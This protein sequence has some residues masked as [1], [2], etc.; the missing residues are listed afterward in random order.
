MTEKNINLKCNCAACE[1]SEKHKTESKKPYRYMAESKFKISDLLMQL[2]VPVILTFLIGLNAFAV[3]PILSFVAAYL[4]N[5]LF[6]CAACSYHHEGVANCG[7]F[8]KSVFKYKRHNKPWTIMQNVF[9]WILLY[10]FMIGP[11]LIVLAYMNKWLQFNVA[12]AMIPLGL[13]A[14][15]ISVCPGCR[16][17]NVCLLGMLV[18]KFNKVSV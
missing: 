17:R 3:V 4:F 18:K 9:G 14:N 8:P 1:H 6:F 16:Q 13:V 11:T 2:L 7:C 15:A 10:S 12:F 5:S